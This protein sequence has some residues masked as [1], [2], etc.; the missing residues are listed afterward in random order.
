ML[1]GDFFLGGVVAASL[2]KLALRLRQLGLKTRVVNQVS[3]QVMLYA[4]SILRLGEA[5]ALTHPID[6][7]SVSR[8]VTAL[9]VLSRRPPPSCPLVRPSRAVP[10]P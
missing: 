1:S 5:K 3:A 10:A 7:D 9:Q 4:T 2:A 8:I 6:D